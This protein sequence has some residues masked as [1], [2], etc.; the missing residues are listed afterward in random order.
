M[1]L[2]KLLISSV[3]ISILTLTHANAGKQVYEYKVKARRANGWLG[4]FG[5]HT[6]ACV[7]RKKKK[8]GHMR[9][10]RNYGCFSQ[11]GENRGGHT[12]SR[13]LAIR[14]SKSKKGF[15]GSKCTTRHP[16]CSLKTQDYNYAIWGLCHQA[17][18]MFLYG[19]N[20]YARISSNTRGYMNRVHSFDLFGTYGHNW[21]AC[22][23]ACYRESSW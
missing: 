22:K 10:I 8:H 9:T 14:N 1:K 18:N 23:R 21:K 12:I 16:A 19:I 3:L 4:A 15:R 2:N 13:F 7:K 6:Y 11:V 20:K 17:T 5:D